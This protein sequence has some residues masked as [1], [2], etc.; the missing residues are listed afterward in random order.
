MQGK[1]RASVEVCGSR[2]LRLG[3]ALMHSPGT[4]T[5]NDLPVSRNQGH[6]AGA[7][8]VPITTAVARNDEV[9]V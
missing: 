8:A 9:T 1:P 2:R 3:E 5:S 7:A 6:G 4:R